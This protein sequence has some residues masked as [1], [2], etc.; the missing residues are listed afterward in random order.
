MS[1]HRIPTYLTAAARLGAAQELKQV[2]IVVLRDGVRELYLADDLGVRKCE[3]R[4]MYTP[5]AA[6][7]RQA[8]PF[9]FK[10][11]RIA[12]DP[13]DAKDPSGPH[14]RERERVFKV[15]EHLGTMPEGV[16]SE[17]LAR[18]EDVGVPVWNWPSENLPYR[19]TFP[20]EDD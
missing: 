14:K 11:K 15:V 17:V 9:Y 6:R 18:A 4:W 16:R 20:G 8:R 19:V 1:E 5:S 7:R 2:V 13:Y 12:M 10:V 3:P